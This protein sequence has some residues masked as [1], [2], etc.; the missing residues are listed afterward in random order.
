MPSEIFVLFFFVFVCTIILF[1]KSFYG[2]IEKKDLWGPEK[3]GNSLWPFLSPLFLPGLTGVGSAAALLTSCFGGIRVGGRWEGRE[4]TRR[5][6]LD[7]RI[8]TCPVSEQT[9][10]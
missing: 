4:D 2:F 9:K 7:T 8:W 5:A 3:V 6:S 1:F 10:K